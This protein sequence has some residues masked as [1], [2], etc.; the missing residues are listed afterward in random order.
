[1]SMRP[2]SG[3][4]IWPVA[5]RTVDTLHTGPFDHR[6]IEPRRLATP[7]RYS[8]LLANGIWYLLQD[9]TTLVGQTV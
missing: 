8:W 7:A 1:M 3:L 5:C 6:D 2:T 9:E 4:E